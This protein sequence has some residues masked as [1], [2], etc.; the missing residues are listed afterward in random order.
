M[1][2]NRSN[3]IFKQVSNGETIDQSSL[4]YASSAKNFL[5]W[6]A[7]NGKLLKEEMEAAY[8]RVA[9]DIN[10]MLAGELDNTD[11]EKQELC[12]ALKEKSRQYRHGLELDAR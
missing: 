3:R 7:E 5:D 10:L 11:N 2:R 12:A 6:G 9:E 4:C 8:S 1:Q